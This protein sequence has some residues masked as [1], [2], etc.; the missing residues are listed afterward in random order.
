[1]CTDIGRV[2]GLLCVDAEQ[3]QVLPDHLQT[4]IYIDEIH[5]YLLNSSDRHT[6][7]KLRANSRTSTK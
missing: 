6:P 3:S 2:S 5:G 4:H 7:Y 1:M